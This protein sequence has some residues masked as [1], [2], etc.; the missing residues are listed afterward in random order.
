MSRTTDLAGAATPPASTSTRSEEFPARRRI[1]AGILLAVSN[2]MVM[3]DLTIA[4]VSV[5]A[6]AGNLGITL[7]QGT[8]II[9]SYAVAEAVSVPLTAWL[10]QRFG[11]V[12]V[13]LL[14]MAGFGIFS[15]LCGLSVTLGMLVAARIGQGLCGGPIMPL[16]QALMMRVFPPEQRPAAMGMWA[17]TVIMAPA[18]G[19]LIGGYIT[20]EWNW[21]WIF[22]IN[23]PISIL[24]VGLAYVLLEGLETPMRKVPIDRIGLALMV[25]WIACVQI[26]LDIGRQHAWFE[27]WKIVVLAMG[28]AL[29]LILFV[30][31]ELTED[32]PVVELRIF[33]HRGFTVIL[34]TLTLSFS[35]FF[36]GVVA[37]PQWLQTAMGYSAFDAGRIVA[38]QA[39]VALCSAP[40]VAK[41]MAKVDFRILVSCGLVW[42]G[43]AS[44]LRTEWTSTTDF[45]TIALTM[46]AQGVAVPFMMVPL[47]TASLSAVGREETAAAAGLQNFARSVALAFA[48]SA[49]MTVWLDAQRVARSDLVGRLQPEQAQVALA[50]AGMTQDQT[51]EIISAMVEGEATMMAL[52]YTFTISACVMFLAAAIIWLSPRISV[53][54]DNTPSH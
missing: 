20:D 32:H 4:N 54:M 1:A 41:L 38:F 40:L 8:W 47:T 31:W 21:H 48:T 44:L 33:R 37:V 5:P 36:A 13:Y 18:L 30:I 19:P 26:T 34:V 27:D 51:R 11:T 22:L 24:C 23:V 49:V 7:E 46:C 9:T 29:G 43:L 42:M 14:A 17:M 39:M 28:G 15:L 35:S 10:A 12:R 45:W 16:S 52:N 53:T 6:I 2:F 25:F 50:T 3:L